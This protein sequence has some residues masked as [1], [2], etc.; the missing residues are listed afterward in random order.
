[1]E[2]QTPQGATQHY[3]VLDMIEESGT[4]GTTVIVLAGKWLDM[5]AY[6]ATLEVDGIRTKGTYAV[7]GGDSS[8]DAIKFIG[9]FTPRR[10]V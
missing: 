7:W 9:T 1:M 4:G 6:A 5:G 2:V 3:T 8:L 10:H